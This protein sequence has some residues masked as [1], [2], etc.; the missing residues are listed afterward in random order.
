MH[1][2]AGDTADIGGDA[3]DAAVMTSPA[4][5]ER[6]ASALASGVRRWLR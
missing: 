6:F 5:Q 2:G 1:L 4:G 3:G